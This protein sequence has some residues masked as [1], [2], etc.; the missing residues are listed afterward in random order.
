MCILYYILYS[1]SANRDREDYLPH[2]A[3]DHGNGTL[4]INPVNEI[5][6]N[7]KFCCDAINEHGQQSN[8]ITLNILSESYA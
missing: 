2:T 7:R 8:C 1:W 6:G 4:T 5:D 3:T